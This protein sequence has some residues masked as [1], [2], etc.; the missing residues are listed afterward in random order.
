MKK[1]KIKNNLGEE[2][3]VSEKFAESFNKAKN[4]SRS[5]GEDFGENN[6]IPIEEF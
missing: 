6:Q 2:V 5:L 3:L 1:I 4:Y